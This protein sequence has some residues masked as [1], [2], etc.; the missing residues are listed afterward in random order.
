MNIFDQFGIQWKLLLAQAINFG[1]L[2]YILKRFLYAPVLKM[3]EDR[4]AKIA[5]S[6]KEAEEIEIKLAK[7]EEDRQKTLGKALDE[8]KDIINEA[9]ESAQQ[10]IADAHKKAQADIADLVDKAEQSIGQERD[11]MHQEIREE[12]SDMVVSSLKAVTGKVLTKKDQ[13]ELVDKNLKGL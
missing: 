9:K 11:R 8:G 13:E 5:Q 3:L 7:T 12:L 1:I 10:I 6:L 2:L 4:K